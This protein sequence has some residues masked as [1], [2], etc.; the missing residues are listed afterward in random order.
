MYTLINDNFKNLMNNVDVQNEIYNY[1]D[2][3]QQIFGILSI[4]ADEKYFLTFCKLEE[5][6]NL[7]EILNY[8]RNHSDSNIII[9][10]YSDLNSM[11]IEKQY[12]DAIQYKDDIQFKNILNKIIEFDKN[13]GAYYIFCDRLVLFKN[14]SSSSKT[15]H[16]SESTNNISL[17]SLEDFVN[18]PVDEDDDDINEIDSINENSNK[19]KEL[20]KDVLTIKEI[21]K[22]LEIFIK[23]PEDSTHRAKTISY[24]ENIINDYQPITNINTDIQEENYSNKINNL[25]GSMKTDYIFKF[26]NLSDQSLKEILNLFSKNYS[27]DFENNENKFLLDQYKLDFIIKDIKINYYKET[28]E[29]L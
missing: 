3:C 7:D 23:I 16:S 28:R 9:F 13:I 1:C 10:S 24:F 14:P 12:K 27:Q 6:E 26:G 20:N 2:Y 25:L 18:N 4:D 8:Y 19:L 22:E 5:T 29:Y 21:K 11:D 17:K 15:D